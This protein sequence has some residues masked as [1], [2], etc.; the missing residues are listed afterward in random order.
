MQVKVQ[1]IEAEN[2]EECFAII[3]E[4]LS[5]MPSHCDELAPIKSVP[6][7]SGSRMDRILDLLPEKRNR[8]MT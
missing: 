4:F 6:D 2:E 7:G 8:S 1:A 3:R 5:Y